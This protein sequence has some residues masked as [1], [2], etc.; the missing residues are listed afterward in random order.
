MKLYKRISQM[1]IKTPTDRSFMADITAT[2]AT[3]EFP[4]EKYPRV[5]KTGNNDST[6]LFSPS[7]PKA[8]NLSFGDE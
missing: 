6:S 5:M 4:Y 8:F 2:D 1:K 3:V 7:I